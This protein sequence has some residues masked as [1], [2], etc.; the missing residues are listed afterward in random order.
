MNT[1]DINRILF[2]L[3]P[4]NTCCASNDMFDEY[5]DE[6]AIILE[7][8]EMFPSPLNHANLLDVLKSVFDYCFW[9]NCLSQ[10]KLEEITNEISKL[11][12]V[13]QRP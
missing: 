12:R 4:M 3:D 13:H 9:E 10:Q 7:T 2:N 8:I 1:Q 11:A 6:A 5:E